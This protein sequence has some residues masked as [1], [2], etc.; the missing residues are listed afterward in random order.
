MVEKFNE[1]LKIDGRPPSQRLVYEKRLDRINE[2]ISWNGGT[3]E[4]KIYH[5]VW[6]D[7]V[8][9]IALG[10][11]GKEAALESG[12]KGVLNQND[13]R[14][15]IFENGVH[16]GVAATFGDIVADLEKVA[17]TEKY[18]VEL[19]GVLFFRSA[20]LLDHHEV[21]YGDATL[22]RYQPNEEVIK[23]ITERIPLIYNVPPIVF[24]QYLDAIA[25]NEDVKYHTKG[26]DLSS[27][28]TGGKNNYLTYVMIIA[29]ICG[30][31]PVSEIAKKLLRTNVS[32][33]GI[34]KALEILP[35]LQN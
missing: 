35:H 14:P 7:E 20:F 25:L 29:V 32:A 9:R 21:Q 27:A 17:K 6:E 24:M 2:A 31:L 18:C 33:I 22:Y 4:E 23:Y 19:L 28:A 34:N 30:D 16:M 26:K 10:K 15:D 13:M 3:F 1:I 11:P 12:Y 5:G 8:Y